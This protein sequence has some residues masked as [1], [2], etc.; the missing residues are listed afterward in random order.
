M[1]RVEIL[2]F[3][4]FEDNLN[5]SLPSKGMVKKIYRLLYA[6][7][8]IAVLITT[9]SY[10]DEAKPDTEK[11]DSL[12]DLP[13]EALMDID[14]EIVSSAS[15]YNQKV[16]EA[17][18]YISLVTAEDIKRYGY[19]TL[20]E[21][22]NSVGGFYTKNGRDYNYTGIRG[23]A[24]PGD[25]DTRML[26]LLDGHRLNEPL[27][28]Y[29]GTGFDA[30]VDVGLIERIEIIRGPGSTIYGANAQLAVINIISK[31]GVVLKGG[32]VSASAGTFDSY[33]HRFSAGGTIGEKG[34]YMVSYSG[35]DSDG[36][37][38]YFVPG[39]NSSATNN[40]IA[41]NLDGEQ[42]KNI[43]ASLN[44]EGLQLEAAGVFRDRIVPTG[45]YGVIF[46]APGYKVKDARSFISASYNRKIQET[47]DVTL[48]VAYDRYEYIGD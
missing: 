9:L 26:F 41:R 34:D 13:I 11:N 33:K 43:F 16:T 30:I 6:T 36:N 12:L 40:G 24:R 45:S 5:C 39:M 48:K 29:S 32:E 17:P 18:A 8:F 37:K 31:K 47:V 10:S 4:R 1:N 15:R 23:F 35:Y 44:F 46:N 25:F 42:A 2:K 19:R 22:L 27:Y 21:I 28:G 20:S 3:W 7:I 14:V 38:S